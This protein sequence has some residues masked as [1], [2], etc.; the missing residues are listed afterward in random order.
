M[1]ATQVCRYLGLTYRQ[2]DYLRQ[3]GLLPNTGSGVVHDLAPD[4]VARLGVATALAR[5]A[6]D[7]TWPRMAAACLSA[8]PSPPPSGWVCLAADGS[9]SFGALEDILEGLVTGGVVAE[10]GE[11]EASTAAA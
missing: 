1:R 2:L 5:V 9:L 6:G 8:H 11:L 10:F 7:R 4:L 3:Q